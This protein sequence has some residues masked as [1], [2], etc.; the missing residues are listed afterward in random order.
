MTTSRDR[1]LSKGP[2]LKAPDK[3]FKRIQIKFSKDIA[4]SFDM[5]NATL[6]GL[7]VEAG[8]EMGFSLERCPQIL[9]L[10]LKSLLNI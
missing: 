3:N 7:E 6:K 1:D 4:R 5:E 2:L 9:T 10:T 8:H